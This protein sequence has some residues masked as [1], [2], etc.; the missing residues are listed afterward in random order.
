[1]RET[2]GRRK[3]SGSSVLGGEMDWP[4]CMHGRRAVH[5]NFC[6]AIW[7]EGEIGK[8]FELGNELWGLT[9]EEEWIYWLSD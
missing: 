8:G 2:G 9:Q 5:K 7:R 3:L 1:V 6:S 4:Y